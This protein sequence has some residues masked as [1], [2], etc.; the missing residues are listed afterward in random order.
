MQGRLKLTNYTAFL[1]EVAQKPLRVTAAKTVFCS[2]YFVGTTRY[3][4]FFFAL[5]DNWK[6]LLFII[7]YRFSVYRY[8]LLIV[9]ML[10][11][12]LKPV[13]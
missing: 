11:L 4:E 3:D 5:C 10:L 1:K 6:T 7:V 2:V 9:T 13:F 8:S 12:S